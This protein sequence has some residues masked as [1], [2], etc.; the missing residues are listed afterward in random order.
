MLE[1]N[2]PPP[3]CKLNNFMN[4]D[5]VSNHVTVISHAFYPAQIETN[6]KS[7]YVALE[8]KGI[9]FLAELRRPG[10]TSTLN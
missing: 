5:E 9:L 6:G 2:I 10:S 4:S 1:N 3:S 8:G 7:I